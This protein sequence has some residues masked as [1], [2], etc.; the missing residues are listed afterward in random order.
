MSRVV[1]KKKND[2]VEDE[3][4]VVTHQS[5]TVRPVDEEQDFDIW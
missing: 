3:N 2:D 4:L 1:D 5:Q